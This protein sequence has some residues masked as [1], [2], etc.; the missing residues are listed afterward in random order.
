MSK[1]QE[2]SEAIMRLTDEAIKK[3]ADLEIF[4]EFQKMPVWYPYGIPNQLNDTDSDE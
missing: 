1:E 3:K 4:E 2:I